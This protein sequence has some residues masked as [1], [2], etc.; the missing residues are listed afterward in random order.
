MKVLGQVYEYLWGEPLSPRLIDKYMGW[1]PLEIS[2][3]WLSIEK[4]IPMYI[5]DDAGMWLFSLEWNDPLLKAIQKYMNAIGTDMACLIMTTPD[6]SYI[7][8]KIRKLPGM[9]RVKIIPTKSR[10]SESPAEAYARRAIGYQPR[11]LPDLR[12]YYMRKLFRDEFNALLPDE[13]HDY[14]LPIRRKYTQLAKQRIWEEIQKRG[15][16]QPEFIEIAK[17]LIEEKVMEA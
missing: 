7:L 9:I 17:R 15:K 1:H 16:K 4:K 5:W 12:K 11:Y 10:Y 14:Y 3:A 6:P 2:K 13:I 8:T